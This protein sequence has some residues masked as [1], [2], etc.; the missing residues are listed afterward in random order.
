MQP[1]GGVI[2]VIDTRPSEPK[3][4]MELKVKKG[5]ARPVAAVDGQPPES[6]NEDEQHSRDAAGG[7]AEAAGVLTAVDED[8]E[9]AE[10]AEV[11]ADFDY[12]TEG[13]E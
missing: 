7:A 9:G 3:T 6:R 12:L 13:E 1:T 2:V 11:P 5:S 8:E 10:E 4:L